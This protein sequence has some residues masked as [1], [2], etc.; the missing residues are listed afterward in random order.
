MGSQIMCLLV[1]MQNSNLQIKLC[2]KCA[3]GEVIEVYV[4][5]HTY[6]Y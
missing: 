3:S 5:L 1:A 2:G 6:A 4:G